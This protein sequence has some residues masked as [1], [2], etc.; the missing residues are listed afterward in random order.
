[1]NKEETLKD[2]FYNKLSF[3]SSMKALVSKIMY[4]Y[5]NYA[6]YMKY[7]NMFIRLNL[8]EEQTK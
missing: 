2:L 3:D 6:D 7:G 4:P 1:M 5:T 8:I